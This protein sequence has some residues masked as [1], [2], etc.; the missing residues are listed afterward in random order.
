MI[1]SSIT[2]AHSFSAIRALDA[3]PAKYV[4]REAGRRRS[5]SAEQPGGPIHW[6]SRAFCAHITASHW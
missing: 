5:H 2:R 3:M 1:L 4:G 6:K